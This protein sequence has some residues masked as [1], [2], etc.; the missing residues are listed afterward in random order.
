MG[1][2]CTKIQL[3]RK[4]GSERDATQWASRASTPT[5]AV[6]NLALPSTLG[7]HG[8]APQGVEP[9]LSRNATPGAL[10][11]LLGVACEEDV[12]RAV[13]PFMITT[14][15]VHRAHC[16]ADAV[17]DV[18]VQLLDEDRKSKEQGACG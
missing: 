17:R 5:E 8:S 9:I 11:I 1:Q 12:F 4:R 14:A 7:V 18:Y 6:S 16:Y 10:R 2:T 13:D 15:D 3:H